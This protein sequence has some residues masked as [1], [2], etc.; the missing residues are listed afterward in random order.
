MLKEN[1]QKLAA[2]PALA[3]PCYCYD[4]QLI[5]ATLST[6]RRLSDSY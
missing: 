4:M 2:L 6:V 1:I 5:D 3:T